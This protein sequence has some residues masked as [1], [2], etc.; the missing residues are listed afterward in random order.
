MAHSTLL[1]SRLGDAAESAASEASPALIWLGRLGFA[2]KGLVYILIG[3]LT[4]RAVVGDQDAASTDSQ[5]VMRHVLDMP[6]GSAILAVI[7]VGLL[8]YAIW[9]VVQ[10]ALD[11]ERKGTDPKG[12][13]VRG[14][15]VI[16]AGVHVL[17][18]VSAFQLVR[19][20][21]AMSGGEQS[22]Q[23]AT[24]RLM[25]QPFGPVL[26]AAVGLCLAGAGL[27]QLYRA[28]STDFRKKLQIDAQD[29]DAMMLAGRLGYAARGVTFLIMGG[30]LGMAAFR[31]APDEAKG[32]AG[33]LATLAQQPYGQLLVG[34]VAAGLAAY[35]VFMFVEARYRRMVISH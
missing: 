13:W 32:I 11:T 30:F 23:D 34:V 27:F 29:S 20:A 2:C 5:A 22:T 8:G 10:A 19:G 7:G 12:L 15:Y 28:Y 17:L 4:A 1:T 18:S 24:A 16:S 25:Q 6:F 33:A 35:G 3:A 21:S 26:V 9:R 31:Q 14:A